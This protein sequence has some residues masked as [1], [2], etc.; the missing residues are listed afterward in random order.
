[1]DNNISSFNSRQFHYIALAGICFIAVFI[2]WLYIS[3]PV[4]YDEGV[5]FVYYASKPLWIGLSNYSLPNNHVFHTLLMHIMYSIF[6]DQ[7]WALRLPAFFA[8]VLIV[9]ATYFIIRRHYG[10]NAGIIAAGLTASS[11]IL[12]EYSTNARG[13]TFIVLFFLLMLFFAEMV[14]SLQGRRHAWCFIVLGGLAFWTI[15]VMIYP[16]GVILCSMLMSAQK[17]AEGRKE[18]L[19]RVLFCLIGTLFLTVVLYY[20]VVRFS[21]IMALINHGFIQPL[22]WRDLFNGIPRVLHS[23]WV[24]WQRDIPV[25]ISIILTATFVGAK[26]FRRSI[27]S[28]SVGLLLPILFLGLIFLLGQR[29]LPYERSLLF[30]LPIYL[31]ISAAGIVFFFRL[32]PDDRKMRACSLLAVVLASGLGMCVVSHDS[33]YLSEET[34]GAKGC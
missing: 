28:Q 30:I 27:V 17:L 6:G 26:I 5:T 11:S 21:G 33:I 24:L 4:R 18:A 32:M 22:P 3:Q 13:Y 9:P 7:F 1:M 23:T 20:P 31:G 25:F 14:V 16:F 12:I 2:R 10:W 8:G 34:G 19:G 15:P 29:V